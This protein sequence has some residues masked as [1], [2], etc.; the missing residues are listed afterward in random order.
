[1]GPVSQMKI[2]A[3][4]HQK[5]MYQVGR[6]SVKIKLNSIYHHQSPRHNGHL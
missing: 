6:I 4:H 1:M 5:W 3:P 2:S